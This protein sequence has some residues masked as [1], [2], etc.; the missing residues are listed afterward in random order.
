MNDQP[1]KD[2][3]TLRKTNE[4]V[5]RKKLQLE[6]QQAC[7]DEVVAFGECA[8]RNHLLVVFNCRKENATSK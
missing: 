7:K 1:R 2:R 4:E 5:L 3:M 8:K 6:A